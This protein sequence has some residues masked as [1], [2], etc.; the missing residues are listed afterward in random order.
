MEPFRTLARYS[1]N[2]HRSFAEEHDGREKWDYSGTI[3]FDVHKGVLT[4]E[5]TRARKQE[6]LTQNAQLDLL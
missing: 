3:R 6:A 1:W 5:S 4:D 2:L